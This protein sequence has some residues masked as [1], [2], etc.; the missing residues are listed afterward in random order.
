ML[1]GSEVAGW[2]VGSPLIWPRLNNV[3]FWHK[4]DERGPLINVRSQ[5]NSRHQI[6]RA[7]RPLLT[8]SRHFAWHAHFS[9]ARCRGATP[10]HVVK[11][12]LHVE[13]AP[14]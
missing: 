5:R 13:G 8:Q 14:R 2:R 11:L 9:N 10:D 12:D 4:A 3:R 7:S 1:E 6:L